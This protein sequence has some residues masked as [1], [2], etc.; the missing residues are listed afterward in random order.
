MVKGIVVNT[1]LRR[2]LRNHVISSC[3]GAWLA[4]VNNDTRL[5]TPSARSLEP[6][7]VI[8]RHFITVLNDMLESNDCYP[9]HYITGTT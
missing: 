6:F 7:Y 2:P 3:M 8:Y 1:R 9:S 4:V 5:S